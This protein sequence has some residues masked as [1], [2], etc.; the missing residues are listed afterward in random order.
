MQSLPPAPPKDRSLT[1]ILEI[2]PGLFGFLGFGWIYAGQTSTG[3]VWL[4]A[5]LAWHLLIE[6]P[7]AIFTASIGLCF[8]LPL[9]LIAVV[10][11]A[12][13]LHSFTAQHPERFR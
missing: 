5:F 3:V 13:T 7:V 9:D 1:L 8:T 6:L 12:V 4:V 2:L 11:S 10:I